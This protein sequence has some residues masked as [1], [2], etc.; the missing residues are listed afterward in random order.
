MHFLFL[1]NILDFCDQI[2][3][4]KLLL[5]NDF[6]NAGTYHTSYPRIETAI[7]LGQE[8]FVG[9]DFCQQ[10]L[11]EDWLKSKSTGN[12]IQW[13]VSNLLDILL[14]CISSIIFLPL[15]VIGYMFVHLRQLCKGKTPE[16]DSKQLDER[17]DYST[18][19]ALKEMAHFL[20]YPINRFI[21]DC[22]VLV[23]YIIVLFATGIQMQ[24]ERRG[25]ESK[26]TSLELCCEI[27]IFLTSIGFLLNEFK[28]MRL[29]ICFHIGNFIF[30]SVGLAAVLVSLGIGYCRK[31]FF[32]IEPVWKEIGFC[33]YA[34]GITMMVL[35]I[36]NFLLLA[37]NLGPIAISVI[38]V[39]HDIFFIFL[40]YISMLL[41]FGLGIHNI[42]KS[43]KNDGMADECKH[44]V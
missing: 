42:M 22:S 17:Q 5:M 12:I 43:V 36:S 39:F 32:E 44:E 27:Y 24:D 7:K 1:V 4:A 11:R 26:T 25:K 6:E 9:N 21:I 16:V 40:Y 33:L 29:G 18:S 28:A 2:D 14:Y 34:F 13:Q 15:H 41:G 10:I 20:T 8:E 3:E 37:R 23:F 35:R 31:Y 19:N 30:H 38:S